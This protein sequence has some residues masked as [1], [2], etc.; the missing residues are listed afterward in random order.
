MGVVAGRPQFS[1][2]WLEASVPPHAGLSITVQV[3]SWCGR[4]L[5][6]KAEQIIYSPSPMAEWGILTVSG[7][8]ESCHPQDQDQ[9]QEIMQKSSVTK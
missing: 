4:F 8:V 7:M 1:G 5:N 2:Y 6:C 9:S 3:S